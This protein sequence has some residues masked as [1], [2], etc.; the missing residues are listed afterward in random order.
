MSV[1]PTSGVDRAIPRGG[2]DATP[3]VI[4]GRDLLP[5][6]HRESERGAGTWVGGGDVPPGADPEVWL[7]LS[8]E[9]RMFFSRMKASGPLEYGPDRAHGPAQLFRGRR[10]YVKV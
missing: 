2:E 1:G 5:A 8:P 3:R 7:G 10:L 9:E 4:P 6:R